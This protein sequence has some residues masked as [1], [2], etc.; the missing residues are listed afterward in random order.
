MKDKIKPGTAIINADHI[1]TTLVLSSTLFCHDPSRI[2]R[3]TRSSVLAWNYTSIIPDSRK[4]V[5]LG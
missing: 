1:S 2:E 3:D 4:V 5:K